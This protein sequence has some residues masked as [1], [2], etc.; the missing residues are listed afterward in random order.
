MALAPRNATA[1]CSERFV[2]RVPVHRL[3]T[4]RPQLAR[5]TQS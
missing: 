3:T 4:G 5:C 2:T 1:R